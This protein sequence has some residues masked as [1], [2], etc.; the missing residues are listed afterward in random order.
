MI[1]EDRLPKANYHRGADGVARSTRARKRDFREMKFQEAREYECE[2]MLHTF[3]IN[4]FPHWSEAKKRSTSDELKTSINIRVKM[5][6]EKRMKI[7]ASRDDR[8]AR[9]IRVV[10]V[11]SVKAV[12][13]Y[14]LLKYDGKVRIK[15][16]RF[17]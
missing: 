12:N 14:F 8:I 16:L 3:G 4:A 11:E 2:Q 9:N 10:S 6:T 15:S 17:K 7:K 1:S 5:Q 13:G